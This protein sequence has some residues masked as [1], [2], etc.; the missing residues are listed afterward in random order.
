MA[1]LSHKTI[2]RYVV[3]IAV[4]VY[5]NNPIISQINSLSRSPGCV[6]NIII[7]HGILYLK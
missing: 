1:I 2:K 7:D 6:K 5:I 4:G 3:A